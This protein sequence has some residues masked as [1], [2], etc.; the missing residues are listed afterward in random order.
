MFTTIACCQWQQGK[1]SERC[2]VWPQRSNISWGLS[3]FFVSSTKRKKKTLWF[4]DPP[5]QLHSEIYYRTRKTTIYFSKTI[6][7]NSLFCC[8]SATQTEYIMQWLAWL[9]T[10]CRGSTFHSPRSHSPAALVH[11]CLCDK[12]RS[13]R[14]ASSHR[15][16]LTFLSVRWFQEAAET[17][18]EKVRSGSNCCSFLTSASAKSCDRASVRWPRFPS[19]GRY[20]FFLQF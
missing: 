14:M 8:C 10:A 5:L 9:L 11:T 16:R 18:K 7:Y 19:G 3:D 20:H 15:H 6:C 12:S 17:E 13:N 2:R 1:T 4:G